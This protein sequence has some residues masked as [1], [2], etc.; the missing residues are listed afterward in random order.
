MKKVF[1]VL[2]LSLGLLAC[3]TTKVETDVQTATSVLC[4]FEPSLASI[5]AIITAAYGG[6]ATEALVNTIAT[7]VCAVVTATPST[8]AGLTQWVYPNTNVVIQGNFV[9]KKGK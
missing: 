3:N 7:N 5:A 9:A 8:K 2:F 6:A 4:G 1:L